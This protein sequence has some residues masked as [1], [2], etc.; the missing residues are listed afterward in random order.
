VIDGVAYHYSL[1]ATLDEI[2]TPQMGLATLVSALGSLADRTPWIMDS[3]S[4][5]DRQIAAVRRDHPDE[6]TEYRYEAR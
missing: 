2:P 6:C 3:E 1:M 5:N 4:M